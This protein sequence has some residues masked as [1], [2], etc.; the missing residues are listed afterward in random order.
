MLNHT[1]VMSIEKKYNK[2]DDSIKQ[3]LLEFSTVELVSLLF[4]GHPTGRRGLMR[5]PFRN[6]KHPSF[7]CFIAHDGISRWKDQSTGE[8]GDN[9]DLFRIVYPGYTY[10]E[11]VDQLSQLVLHK[12]AYLDPSAEVVIRP[13]AAAR[14]TSYSRNIEPE[15]ESVLKVVSDL[16]LND[17]RVPAELRDYWRSRGISDEVITQVC[18]YV[19]FENSNRKGMT[20][21]DR[22]SGLPIVD[23]NGV[24]LKDDGRCDAICLYNDIGGHVFR[25]PQTESHKGFKGG[26]SSFVTTLLANG[27]R[28]WDYSRVQFYGQGDGSVQFFH[29]QQYAADN[30]ILYVNPAQGFNCLRPEN[31]A[32]ATAFLSEWKGH[33]LDARDIRCLSAVLNS[34]NC[35][36]YSKAV[37]V[38]GM[39]DG[40]SDKELDRILGRVSPDHDLVVLNSI[41]N[42]RWAVPFL[43]RHQQVVIM[44]DNDLS[45]GAGQ[46]AYNQLCSDV[47]SF[48]K[49]TGTNSILFNGSNQYAEHKDLNEAL[50]ARKGLK[51]PERKMNQ[52]KR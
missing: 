5:S 12:S 22:N 52:Q 24:E 2:I 27:Y 11:A 47:A 14:R 25:V 20:L 37:V 19:V 9:I 41:S 39:F 4:P 13:R 38:E 35:P 48:N 49:A 21:I 26:T 46:K 18:R 10:T 40:L 17:S 31:V 7:S 23:K 28:P 30:G 44:M 15:R 1:S 29:Y 8:T 3:S 42:I 51:K 45:S 50:V 33:C 16:P 43:A 36:A 34:L 6:D 32:F